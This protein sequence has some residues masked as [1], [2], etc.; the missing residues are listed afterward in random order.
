MPE[1]QEKKPKS[2]EPPPKNQNSVPSQPSSTSK[3]CHNGGGP[4]NAANS[5]SNN[6]NTTEITGQLGKYK[7]GQIDNQ[8]QPA[9]SAQQ[10][11]SNILMDEKVL[12]LYKQLLQNPKNQDMKISEANQLLQLLNAN[13]TNLNQFNQ[14]NIQNNVAQQNVMNVVQGDYNYNPSHHQH[15]QNINVTQNVNI[16]IQAPATTTQLFNTASTDSATTNFQNTTTTVQNNLDLANAMIAKNLSLQTILT[17]N[18]NISP[19]LLKYLTTTEL[20]QI[21]SHYNAKNLDTEEQLKQIEQ[22][23]LQN[24]QQLEQLQLQEEELKRSLSSESARKKATSSPGPVLNQHLVHNRVQYLQNKAQHL[25]PKL[26]HVGINANRLKDF[27]QSITAKL[28]NLNQ[29]NNANRQ[30]SQ[31]LINKIQASC[32]SSAT[33]TPTN[34]SSTPISTSTST[35]TTSNSTPT[36]NPLN[37]PLVTALSQ[38]ILNQQ[39]EAR[40]QQGLPLLTEPMTNQQ[41]IAYAKQFNQQQQNLNATNNSSQPKHVTH[42]NLGS[43]GQNHFNT[44]NPTHI[45]PANAPVT[46]INLTNTH[47]NTQNTHPSPNQI[48][49]PPP[50]ECPSNN[51]NLS[52]MST[53]SNS[54][55]PKRNIKKAR[56]REA[57]ELAEILQTA[58]FKTQNEIV[59]DLIRSGQKLPKEPRM[60]NF[61][62]TNNLKQNNLPSLNQA[63][64]SKKRSQNQVSVMFV[65]NPKNNRKR[66]Q[67]RPK[68]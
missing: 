27:N 29:H 34:S 23:K 52:N 67:K 28:E 50:S 42:F 16:N 49:L 17:A 14:T 44:N 38:Q 13:S 33:S 5:N 26:E 47:T 39:N 36:I 22:Q 43:L 9:S 37:N 32:L 65:Q 60:S 63:V 58:P 10:P 21:L 4:Q 8:S 53:N 6:S 40:Q 7:I 61:S 64:E 35:T 66:S 3:T 62:T 56:R 59:N 19:E 11:N 48:P 18:C 31:D 24:Q 51:S 1:K 46:H 55:S 54:M 30:I 45:Q 15:N 68:N 41:L 25:S 57:S 12:E 2:S 20:E